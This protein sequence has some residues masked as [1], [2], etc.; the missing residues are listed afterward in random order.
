MNLPY[1]NYSNSPDISFINCK[2]VVM[3]W[4]RVTEKINKM[5]CSNSSFVT[6]LAA[7]IQSLWCPALHDPTHESKPGLP[8][9]HH[10]PEFIKFMSTESVMLSN[11]LILPSSPFAF[12]LPRHQ[13]LFQRVSSWHR[14]AR[15]LELQ[16]QHHPLQWTDFLQDWLLWSPCCQ[17]TQESSPAPQFNSINSSAFSLLSGPILTSILYY[18]KG[19]SFH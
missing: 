10:F 14:V 15:L 13:G 7:V 19:H 8:V 9:P 4:H 16:L 3:S 12:T 18:W 11:H 1:I 2:T 6:L 17:G 5:L